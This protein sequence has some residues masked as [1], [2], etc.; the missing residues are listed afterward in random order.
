MALVAEVCL[1]P[2]E[3]LFA[4]DAEGGCDEPLG[5]QASVAVFDEVAE[6]PPAK[7]FELFG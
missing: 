3:S 5:E 7:R 6:R 1:V 2:L 4:G